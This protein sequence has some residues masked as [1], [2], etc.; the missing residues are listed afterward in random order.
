M[1]PIPAVAHAQIAIVLGTA[2]ILAP[3]VVLAIIA[4]VQKERRKARLLR[5]IRAMRR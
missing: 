5:R 3:F 2:M 1:S 4:R